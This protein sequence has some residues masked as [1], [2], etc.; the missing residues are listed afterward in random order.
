[1]DGNLFLGTAHLLRNRGSG[2]A[3][4]RSAISRAYY[5]CFIV[6]RKL[7]FRT[8]SQNSRKIAH[9]KSEQCIGHKTLKNYLKNGSDDR[10]VCGLGEDFTGLQGN[11]IDADYNMKQTITFN[12]AHDAIEAAEAFFESLSQIPDK[13]I[14][15]AV[16]G[17]IKK[18]YS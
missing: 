18:I 15:D 14:G 13:A 6:T 9:I 1:M 5:A 4:Y 3:D 8:C 12:D 16:D 2:E 10:S 7:A 11:R 17:Y